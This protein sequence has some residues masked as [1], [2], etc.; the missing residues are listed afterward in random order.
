MRAVPE[1]TGRHIGGGRLVFG[2]SSACLPTA[3][4]RDLARKLDRRIPL[5]VAM[6]S[7]LS[8]DADAASYSGASSSCTRSATTFSAMRPVETMPHFRVRPV[9]WSGEGAP[10]SE[11]GGRGMKRVMVTAFHDGPSRT[12]NGPRP[13]LDTRRQGATIVVSVG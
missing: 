2:P 3:A 9:D 8:N 10:G 11:A 13:F 5:I 7:I 6:D 1:R 4:F 12:N